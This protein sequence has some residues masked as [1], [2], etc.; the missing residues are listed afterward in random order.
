MAGIA[1]GLGAGIGGGGAGGRRPP[2]LHRPRLFA[3]LLGTPLGALLLLL[4]LEAAAGAAILEAAG[5]AG[6]ALLAGL[7]NLLASLRF[8]LTLRPG[9]EPLISRYARFDAAGMPDA[10]GR[11]TRRLTWLWALLLGGF[12][13]AFLGAALGAGS[14]APLARL[15][16]LAC[17]GLFLGEHALRRRR[18]PGLGPVSPLGTLRAIWRCH[19]QV[20][21]AS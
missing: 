8:G 2:I 12:A 21:H 1:A 19:R 13:L 15:Q 14:A 7:G 5:R 10:D 9:G 3:A 18:F 17:L 20:R 11:Y 16:P 6:P 4:G